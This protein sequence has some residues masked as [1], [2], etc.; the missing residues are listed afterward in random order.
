MLIALTKWTT[1]S[2][3]GQKKKDWNKKLSVELKLLKAPPLS[4]AKRPDWW[5]KG[6]KWPYD[7]N[8]VSGK[9]GIAKLEIQK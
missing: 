3:R 4:T 9:G 6:R 5:K 1:R 8:A 2:E 7:G